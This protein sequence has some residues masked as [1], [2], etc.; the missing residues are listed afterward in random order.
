MSIR[1]IPLP[2]LLILPLAVLLLQFH[3]IAFWSWAITGAPVAWGWPLLAAPWNG[4]GWSLLFELVNLWAWPRRWHLLAGVTTVLLVAGPLYQVSDPLV[5]DLSGAT[6]ADLHDTPRIRALRD[7]IAA[8]EANLGTYRADWRLRPRV[9][10]AQAELSARHEELA[11][12]L[13]EQ[14]AAARAARLDWRRWAVIAGQ[15]LGILIAQA[16]AVLSVLALCGGHLVAPAL[17]EGID[18]RQSASRP[19]TKMPAV[20]TNGS[21]PPAN[22]SESGERPEKAVIREFAR[23]RGLPTQ[24]A[25]A[26]AISEPPSTL[27]EFANGRPLPEETRRRIWGALRT[28]QM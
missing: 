18:T 8:L 11:A 24:R 2:P 1:Q 19:A 10:G 21:G 6:A 15:L 9:P 13:G 27:S 26:E 7:E 17:G 4:W 25:V 12:L 3:S 20:P 16:G 14:E 28:N 5:R 23:R 22:S